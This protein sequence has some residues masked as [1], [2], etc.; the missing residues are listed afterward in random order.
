MQS[1]LRITTIVGP[2]GK[3]EIESPDLHSGETVEVIILGPET[4]GTKRKSALDIL[5]KAPGHQLFKSAEE[6]DAY[7][8]EERDSWDR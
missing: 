4:P 6:V 8:K 2:G 7:I 1:A 3:I 5:A